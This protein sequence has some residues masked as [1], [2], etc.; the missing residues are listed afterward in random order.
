[1]RNP[2]LHAAASELAGRL[3]ASPAPAA[4]WIGRDAARD[5]ARPAAQR[6]A[7]LG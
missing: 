2:A 6:K 5:L 7:G 4:R 3:A 1:M